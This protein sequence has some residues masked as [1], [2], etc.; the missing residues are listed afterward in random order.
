MAWR[1]SIMRRTGSAAGGLGPMTEMRYPPNS[2]IQNHWLE[3]AAQARFSFCSETGNRDDSKCTMD[4]WKAPC[5]VRVSADSR[6]GCG[7]VINALLKTICPVLG[8]SR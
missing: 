3:A 4:R 6:V 2:H 5:T 7:Q 1:V 8:S